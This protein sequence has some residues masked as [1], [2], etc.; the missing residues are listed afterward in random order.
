MDALP[1]LK[2]D[3]TSNDS[4]Q[5]LDEVSEP[6]YIWRKSS[7]QLSNIMNGIINPGVFSSS[8]SNRSVAV[9]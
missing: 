2:E 4:S 8:H 7:Q 5:T 6:S 1:Q 9:Y 3:S